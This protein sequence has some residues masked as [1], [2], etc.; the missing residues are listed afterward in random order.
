MGGEV[1]PALV[2]FVQH[3]EEVIKYIRKGLIHHGADKLQA[4]IEVAGIN[5]WKS[6]D[7]ENLY[8]CITSDLEDDVIISIVAHDFNG[9]RSKDPHFVPKSAQFG[10]QN[11]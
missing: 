3:R 8:R 5:F 10:V 4:S 9:L 11:G 2:E 1:T 7:V 6:E